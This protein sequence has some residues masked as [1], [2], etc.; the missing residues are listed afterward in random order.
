MQIE[1]LVQ[2]DVSEQVA[3]FISARMDEQLLLTE[4]GGKRLL[5]CL[6]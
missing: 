4:K 2:A 5:L 6:L 3:E 1:T